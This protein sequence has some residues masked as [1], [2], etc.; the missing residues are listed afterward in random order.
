MRHLREIG[1]EYGKWMSMAHTFS[2]VSI[3]GFCWILGVSASRELVAF[4]Q[5]WDV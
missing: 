3:G 2:I 5:L 4:C 1:D